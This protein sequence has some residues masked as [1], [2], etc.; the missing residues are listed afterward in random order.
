VAIKTDL[1]QRRVISTKQGRE[2]ASSKDLEY[3]ECSA[4]SQMYI[5]QSNNRSLN[6]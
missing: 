2:F 6:F 3:F 4:V 1:K 5:L